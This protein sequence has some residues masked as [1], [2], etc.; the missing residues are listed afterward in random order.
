MSKKKV[1][2]KVTVSSLRYKRSRKLERNK[3]IKFKSGTKA[4]HVGPSGVRYHE[5][6]VYDKLRYTVL[7]YLQMSSVD[8]ALVDARLKTITSG[9]EAM[10][11]PQIRHLDGDSSNNKSE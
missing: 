4:G 7:T 10:T 1:K 3:D 9:P 2:K 11:L 6:Y 5:Q 8:K